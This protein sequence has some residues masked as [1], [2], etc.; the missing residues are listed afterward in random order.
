MIPTLDNI[1]FD[2]IYRLN[3]RELKS[4]MRHPQNRFINPIKVKDLVREI[5]NCTNKP[6][7]E[8]RLK[9]QK[10]FFDK[11]PTLMVNTHED[12]SFVVLDG[13]HRKN[14]Y[15]DAISKNIIESEDT[16]LVRVEFHNIPINEEEEMLI[17]LQNSTRWKAIDYVHSLAAYGNENYRNFL[18]LISEPPLLGVVNKYGEPS[19]ENYLEFFSPRCGVALLNGAT[20]KGASDKIKNGNIICAEED[21]MQAQQLKKEIIE[22]SNAVT[23]IISAFRN[24]SYEPLI[25]TWSHY[26]QS[27]I[28]HPNFTLDVIT[29]SIKENPQVLSRFG[30]SHQNYIGIENWTEIFKELSFHFMMKLNQP[31]L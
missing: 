8:E 9:D 21:L 7:A 12:G 17:K 3:A 2:K 5:K 24:D 10:H 18:K 26:R 27:L 4:L 16:E 28:N 6:T 1:D 15:L 19:S 20:S 13:E 11:L 23:S 29:E 31:N 30:V 14:A 25:K 22:I